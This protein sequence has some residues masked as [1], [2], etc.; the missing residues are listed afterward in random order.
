MS[1]D[2]STAA[3]P[4]P[5]V[6]AAFREALERF[7]PDRPALILGHFDADGLS[8]AAILQR[9]LDAPAV[10]PRSAWSA[11]AKTPGPSPSG[12]AGGGSS[13][14]ADRRRSGCARR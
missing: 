12:R 4:R 1:P 2:L 5:I 11:K 14:R 7:E 6:Q 8:A 3:D 13:R 9:A 10:L